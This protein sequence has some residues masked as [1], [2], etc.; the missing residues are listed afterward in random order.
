LVK[1]GTE[2]E[3]LIKERHGKVY[4]GK[5]VRTAGALDAA[6]RTMLAEVRVPNSAHELMPG[7]YGQARFKLKNSQPPIIVPGNTLAIGAEGAH[8]V[9]LDASDSLR[10]HKVKLGRDYGKEVEI[11]DGIGEGER[12]VM[13]PRDTLEEGM[14]VKAVAQ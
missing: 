3:I 1:E 9:A 6:T 8:V 13:N 14:K 10:F 12:I 11:I 7:M 4:V 2:V 5:V